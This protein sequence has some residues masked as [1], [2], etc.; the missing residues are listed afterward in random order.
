MSLCMMG[1]G[2][3]N[4]GLIGPEGNKGC[5]LFSDG[6]KETKSDENPIEVSMY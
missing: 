3:D 1:R 2:R 6:T 5:C 4:H